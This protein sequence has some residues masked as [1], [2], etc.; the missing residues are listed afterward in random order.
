MLLVRYFEFSGERVHF[1]LLLERGELLFSE[2]GAL[3][4][5]E[6]VGHSVG[7]EGSR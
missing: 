5:R 6:L 3:L 1:L 7:V 4:K 2:G